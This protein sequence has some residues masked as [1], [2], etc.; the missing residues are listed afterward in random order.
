MEKTVS[1]SMRADA[2]EVVGLKPEANFFR[3][4]S[5]ASVC[6]YV[7]TYVCTY[8]R[9]YVCTYVR[10]KNLSVYVRASAN[11]TACLAHLANSPKAKGDVRMSA[12]P[13]SGESA[14]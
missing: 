11:S 4:S 1:M 7:Y 5:F 8:V 2:K 13:R 12:E 3:L 10:I 14:D 6:T 9:T